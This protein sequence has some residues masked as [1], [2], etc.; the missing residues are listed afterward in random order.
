MKRQNRMEEGLNPAGF[1]FQQKTA[2]A[3]LQMKP[4]HLIDI[5]QSFEGAYALI[6]KRGREYWVQEGGILEGF[7]VLRIDRN[8]VFLKP[9]HLEDD[10]EIEPVTLDLE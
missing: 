2:E 9:L 7:V 3:G 8:R 4:F 1:L 5:L 10:P 6:E